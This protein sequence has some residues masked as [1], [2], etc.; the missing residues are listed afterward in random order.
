MSRRRIQQVVALSFVL[1]L[2][3]GV[4]ALTAAETG[5][6]P[7]SPTTIERALDSERCDAAL[8]QMQAF[9]ADNFVEQAAATEQPI[10]TGDGV[11][12]Q[13]VW[14][15]FFR[16]I[17][18]SCVDVGATLSELVLFTDAQADALVDDPAAQVIALFTTAQI[19]TVDVVQLTS[20]AAAI[21]VTAGDEATE[22]LNDLFG[23]ALGTDGQL[24]L[25]AP[26]D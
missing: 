12:D 6:D 25:E 13:Q 20:E 10:D 3:L 26:T 16:E 18:A 22:A 17:A 1:T 5:D 24:E 9:L 4:L 15:D 8:E 2:V 23:D 11:E 7:S 14:D 21:C 19:C